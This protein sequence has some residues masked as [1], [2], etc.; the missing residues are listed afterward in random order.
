MIVLAEYRRKAAH[1]LHR[2]GYCGQA[3]AAREQYHDVRCADNG[4]AW[5]WRAHFRCEAFLSLIGAWDDA[6]D[7]GIDAVAFADYV[8]DYRDEAF[9]M[10]VDVS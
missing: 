6:G 10:G 2:C 4:T 7:D 3:I 5:T 8:S 1:G 9:G